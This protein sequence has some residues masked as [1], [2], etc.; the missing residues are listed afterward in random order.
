MDVVNDVR[1]SVWQRQPRELFDDIRERALEQDA[2]EAIGARLDA[3]LGDGGTEHVAEEVLAGCRIMGAGPRRSVERE[4]VEGGAQRLGEAERARAVGRLP[5]LVGAEAGAGAGTS[6][7][8]GPPNEVGHRSLLPIDG[9][10]AQVVREPAI[11]CESASA[12]RE[13]APR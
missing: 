2:R 1:V 13:V 7:C 5:V 10:G 12:P 9:G 3:L 6:S 8:G 4:A 11:I